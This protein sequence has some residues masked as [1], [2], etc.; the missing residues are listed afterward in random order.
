MSTEDTQLTRMDA[1][2]LR[3]Q[4]LLSV[5]AYLQPRHRELSHYL[6]VRA[7]RAAQ[8]PGDSLTDRGVVC[9]ACLA[10]LPDHVVP[11]DAGEVRRARPLRPPT[12]LALWMR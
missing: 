12:R 1:T 11:R 4:Y 2:T 10:L 7:T 6:A 5:S 8:G 3:V 9:D